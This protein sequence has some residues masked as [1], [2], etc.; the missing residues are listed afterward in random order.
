[1]S[2]PTPTDVSQLLIDWSHG[3][4]EALSR[5]MP[6]VYDE[7]RRLAGSYLRR[8]RPDHTLQ[9]T[10]LVHEAFIKLV[11]QELSLQN[12]AHFFGVAA[13]VMRCI[14]VDH[15]R[16]HETAKRGGG[17]QRFTLEEVMDT[18]LESQVDL[19][20]LDDALNDLARLDPQQARIVELR[21]FGGLTIEE[22]AEVLGI[23]PATVKREWRLARTWLHR[24]IS[25]GQKT[26]DRRQ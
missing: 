15:A 3:D 8:E 16:G 18:P 2:S 13:Q 21:Y 5:L 17:A 9:P 26:V 4:R 24:Q 25:S 19:L 10:A 14:L 11:G 7:L 23:S 1:M 12:R 22:T 20:A 6:L